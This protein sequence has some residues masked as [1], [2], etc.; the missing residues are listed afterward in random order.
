MSRFRNLVCLLLTVLAGLN[1]GAQQITGSIRGTVRGP[2]R[3]VGAIGA[4]VPPG[5]PRLASTRTATTDHAGAY[6][7]V[8]LPVGHYELQV[9]AKGFQKYIQQGIIL[10]VNETATVPVHLAVG[11]ESSGIGGECRRAIDSGHG[12]QPGQDGH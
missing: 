5:K 8:E 10:N 1:A 3:R 2:E 4:T 12:N 6:V 7:L 11:A 9:E